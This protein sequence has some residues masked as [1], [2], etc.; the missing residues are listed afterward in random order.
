MKKQTFYRIISIAMIAAILGSAPVGSLSTL[1]LNETDS[2]KQTAQSLPLENT[3]YILSEKISFGDSVKMYGSATGG[4]GDYQYAYYWKQAGTENWGG[5]GFSSETEKSFKPTKETIYNVCIKVKDGNNTVSAVYF[6]VEVKNDFANTSTIS[7]ESISLGEE[8]IMYG[9][10]TGGV[11][12]YQYAY[13]WKQADTENWG[14]FGFSSE[15]QKSFKPTKETTYNI[16]IKAKD[17]NGIVAIQY[18]DIE[19]KNNFVN[20]STISSRNIS[21][22]EEV[23]MYGSATGNIG[24]CTYAYYWKQ[25]GAESPSSQPKKPLTM[26]A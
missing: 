18:F 22:G 20:T 8:V 24:D 10:A 2:A 12:D 11:S 9:S 13:Y 7:A 23:I 3:S 17:S 6:D 1:A 15:I 25:A 14:G 4:V 21:L 5:V 19:V 26:S 16:C